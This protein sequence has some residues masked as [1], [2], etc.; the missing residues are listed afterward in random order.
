MKT[1]T[2][3]GLGLAAIEVI[4]VRKCDIFDTFI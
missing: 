3:I 2:R 4:L 1:S